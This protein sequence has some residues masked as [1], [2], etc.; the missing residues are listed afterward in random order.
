MHSSG[1]QIGLVLNTSCTMNQSATLFERIGGMPAVNSAVEIFYRKVLADESLAHFFTRVS[2][3]G[4]SGKMKAF[5]AYAFGAPLPY[6]AKTMREAHSRMHISE[7]QFDAAANHLIST[8]RELSVPQ[9]LIDEVV[10][11]A[12]STREDVLNK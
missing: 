1:M 2:M 4:Q 9:H 5:L 10:S 6:T 12:L 3:D 8:L 7:S 11:I